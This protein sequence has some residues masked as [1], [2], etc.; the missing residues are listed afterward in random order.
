MNHDA[1]HCFDYDKEKCPKTC[2]RARL[3]EEVINRPELWQI[4]LSYSHFFNT[5]ECEINNSN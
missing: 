2:Y 5:E 1:S 3:T 4:P